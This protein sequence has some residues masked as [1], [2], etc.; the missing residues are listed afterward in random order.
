MRFRIIILLLFLPVKIWPQDTLRHKSDS[1]PEKFYILENVTRQGETL[2]EIT[3]DEINVVKKIGLR[4][5]FAWWRY[6][7][8]VYNVKK[9]YPYSIMVRDKMA[10]VND[11][12]EMM[13]DER[14]RSRF[15][16]EFE[17]EIFADY[18]DDMRSMTITQ[19]KILIKLIDRETRNTSYT[20]IKE[21]RGTI[22]AVFWQGIAR[23]FGSNL[24][25]TYDPFGEDYLIEKVIYEIEA[26]RI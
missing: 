10:E 6:Q 25:E 5:R 9:V 23:I 12:L 1:L 19:G 26:G 3:I 21:Y 11:T 8:L 7:R 18:E 16:K 24:K 22:T 4:E 2:P 20:L 17:K 13:K 15:L 14:E